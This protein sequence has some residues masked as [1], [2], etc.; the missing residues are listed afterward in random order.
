MVA[1][2]SV[3]WFSSRKKPSKS[4]CPYF[5]RLS[6]NCRRLIESPFFIWKKQ[7]F[8]WKKAK[9][10]K[11]LYLKPWI[12]QCSLLKRIYLQNTEERKRNIDFTSSTIL[13]FQRPP[14]KRTTKTKN[15]ASSDEPL[16][17]VHSHSQTFLGNEKLCTWNAII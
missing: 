1:I 11:K 17:Y 6:R 14:S 13:A 7:I 4:V 15:I 12:S 5:C 2:D 8:F 10:Y 3:N 9:I 16:G